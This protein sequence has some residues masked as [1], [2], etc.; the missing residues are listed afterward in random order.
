MKKQKNILIREFFS[1]LLGSIVAIFFGSFYLGFLNQDF[2]IFENNILINS[3][4]FIYIIPLIIYLILKIP[5]TKDIY[6]SND[7]DFPFIINTDLL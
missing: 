2:L 4:I 1:L 5:F 7:F 6:L 3:F